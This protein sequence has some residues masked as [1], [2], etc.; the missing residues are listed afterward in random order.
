[1]KEKKMI[2]IGYSGHAFVAFGILTSAGYNVTGYC[3]K[4]EKELNPFSLKY[5]GSEQ[6]ER[7]LKK[8][9]KNNFFISIGDNATRRK[10]Y[11]DL[12]L[13]DLLS[14]NAIHPFAIIHESVI[15]DKGV[16]ISSGV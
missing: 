8:L 1:M 11:D 6:T 10:V 14:A 15:I 12:S 13:E 4:D 7:A 5:Y 2:L 3:D 16:M 9:R